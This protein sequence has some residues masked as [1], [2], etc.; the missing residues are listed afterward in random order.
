[1]PLPDMSKY[2]PAVGNIFNMLSKHPAIGE[3]LYEF[4]R[5]SIVELKHD[6]ASVLERYY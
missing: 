2:G 6:L 3:V 1:M 4:D 5:D